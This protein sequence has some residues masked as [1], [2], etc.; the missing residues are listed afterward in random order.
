M[1]GWDIGDIPDLTGRTYIVTGA[2]SGL[3]AATTRALTGAGAR[4]IMA[5]R[6]EVKAHAV[7]AEMGE[8]AQV[9]RLDLADLASVR[10]FADGI[11]SAD[12]LINN[13][14]I[15]AVP[16]RRTAD[17]FEMQIGTNHL[18]HFALTGL[19]LDKIRERVVT[20]S[21]GAHAIG[22]IDLADLNWERRRYQ[23]WAAYGQSKLANLMFAYELQRRL[24]AAGSP[25]LSLA[26]HP[27]YAATELQSH[28][29]SFQDFM[30]SVGNRLFAQSAEMGALP[31]LYAAT[32][33]VEPGA[34]YGPGGLRGLRGHP[35][36]SGSSS[37]SRDEMTARRLWE[38]SEQLTKVTYPFGRK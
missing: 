21:S 3:G 20:V 27:G 2:N 29:E 9:R 11:E 26:A 5:C 18:G 1:S 22:R 19:L 37:A 36:R 32:A 8:R 12:V 38:L 23:R 33:E 34:F 13:A 24:A 10:D 7:A 4:V 35:V 15:M 14:G 30:M 31:T 17:G 16:L 25:K 28:T 6:N